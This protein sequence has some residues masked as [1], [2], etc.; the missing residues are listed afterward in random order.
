MNANRFTRALWVV[1][2]LLVFFGVALYLRVVLPYDQV[3][4]GN[5]VKFTTQDAYYFMR[6]VDNLVHNFP[7]LISFDP[8]LSYPNGAILGSHTFYVRF[9]SSV[10]WIFG[11]GSPT[12]HTVDVV[13]AWIPAFLSALMVIPVYFIGKLLFNRWAGILASA[14]IAILPGQFLGVTILGA[15]DRDAIELLLS[16]LLMLFM[17]LAIRSAREKQWTFRSINLRRPP[18]LSKPIMYSLMSGVVL[19][20][21]VLTWRGSFLFVLIFLVYAVIQSIFDYSKHESF[22][23]LSIVG[24]VTFLVALLIFWVASRDPLDSAALAISLIALP[25]LSGL[26]WLLT[27]VKAKAYYYPVAIIGVVLLGV[28][29]L[30][31]A[32][33]SLFHSILN[34]FAVLMPIRNQ[35]TVVEM[36]PFLYPGGYFTFALVWPTYTTGI[37][38]SLIALVVLIY[39]FFKRGKTDYLFVIVWSLI[40]LVGTLE[41]RRFAS[42]FAVNVALLTGYMAIVV[43][44]A[45]RFTVNYVTGRSTGYVSSRLLESTGFKAPATVK[46]AE[47]PQK[48]LKRDYYEILGVPKNAT[49]KQIK[50]ARREQ[51]GQLHD[52]LSDEGQERLKQIDRAYAVLSDHRKRADYDSS[53]YGTELNR[54]E[55]IGREKKDGFRGYSLISIAVASLAVFFLVFFPDFK[56]ADT[57]VGQAA[58][59]A[60]T[61]AWVSSLSWLRDNT[62]QPFDSDAFYYGLYQTP[63]AY[64]ETA[65]GVAAWWDYGYLIMRIAHRLPI[66]DPGAGNRESVARLFTA[67]NEAEANLLASQLNSKYI[68]IDDKT[69]TNFF[70]AITT[71][72]GTRFEQF[73][74]SYEV[75]SNNKLISAQYFY[76]QYFQSLAVRL[77]FYD[78]NE[79][80]PANTSVISY[81]EKTSQDGVLYKQVLS[82]STFPSY[83][84]ANAYI[85][86]QVSGNYKIVS[87]SPFTSPI[88]LDSLQHYKLVYSSTQLSS[89]IPGMPAVKIFEYIS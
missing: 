49:Y 28:G 11:L 69:F 22:D 26:A 62:P 60:P 83:D 21:Y 41:M 15:T 34:Q 23:Y 81:V 77:Y 73:I 5:T 45:V 74:E 76:P 79:V 64:P 56:P 16:T 86:K 89:L 50:K 32:S 8:Y 46:P 67:Q 43:Y 48:G 61:D 53:M 85:A 75:T 14:L 4:V 68:I 36:H 71:Y 65:Y 84:A 31:T 44:Y 20:L 3:F 78:G 33:P 18:V 57:V 59:N 19:A 55:K 12:Q 37:F 29:I 52:A 38:L 9:M 82:T 27:R 7:H 35:S 88:H 66:C 13:G 63:F 58:A 42:F 80:S 17:I 30:Y 39:L 87:Q 54:K 72:A 10:I 25:V 40:M 2:L 51:K 70:G 24:I 47:I 1:I 6:Q